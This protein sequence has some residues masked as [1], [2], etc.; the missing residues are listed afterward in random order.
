VG[1]LPTRR[2]NIRSL[3]TLPKTSSTLAT[4]GK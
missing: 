4:F 2:T 3:L 1:A